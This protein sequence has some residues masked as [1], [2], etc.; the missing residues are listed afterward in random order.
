MGA[1]FVGRIAA[2]L[3]SLAEY[4][5]TRDGTELAA[6]TYPVFRYLVGIDGL[7]LRNGRRV[8]ITV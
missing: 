2:H 1:E 4:G 7:D 6:H 5:R 3:S 8:V